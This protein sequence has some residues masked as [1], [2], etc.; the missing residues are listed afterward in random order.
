M[1]QHFSPQS[2]W[3]ALGTTEKNRAAQKP[4]VISVWVAPIIVGVVV[5]MVSLVVAALLLGN[6]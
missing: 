5:I 4:L 3:Q 6:K 1:N 2:P